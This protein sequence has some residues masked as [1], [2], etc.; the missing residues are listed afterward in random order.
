MRYRLAVARIGLLAFAVHVAAAQGSPLTQPLQFA[1]REPVF[2]SVASGGE[3]VDA[4]RA[5]VLQRRIALEL[6]DASLGDALQTVSR[7][8]GLLINYSSDEL[9]PIGR[10]SVGAHNLTVE[11]AL[12][13]VLL[14][15][16][17]DVEIAGNQ[18][19]LVRRSRVVVPRVVSRRRQ[20][21]GRIEGRVT[22]VRSA[23]P[24]AN[25]TVV[26][27]ATSYHA[28]TKND[29]QY[30]IA[31]IPTGAYTV[32]ARL[33]GHAPLSKRVQIYADSV[34]RI[35]FKLAEAVAALEQV[36]TTAVGDQRRV[37]LGNAI[38]TINADSV[39]RDAP[40]TQVTDVLSGRAP[41]VEVL[42][43]E[44][45]VGV[46]P[47]I[48]IRGLSSFTLSNDPII[49]VD[50]VRVDGT[51]GAVNAT[52]PS[53]THF[54]TPSRLN[55]IDP[56]NIAS[57]DVLKGPSAAT[58]YGTDA[59]NGVIVI[60]TKRGR[61]GVP[62]WDL[63]AEQGMS[64][65]PA[66]YALAWYAWGHTTDSTHAAV[67]CPRTFG[68]GG[69]TIGNG[70]CVIDSVTTYQPLDHRATSLFGTGY[71]SRVGA[72]LSG[73]A[74]Q[75]QYFLSGGYNN[76]TG[77][78]ELP[79]FFQE[80]ERVASG[81]KPIPSYV[82]RPNVMSQATVRG[83]VTAT[84]GP[85][86]DFGFSSGYMSTN[87]RAGDD[88]LALSGATI[89]TGNRNDGFGG[90]GIFGGFYAPSYS[91]ALTTGQDIRRLLNAAN[92]N[93]RP[94]SWLAARATVGLDLGNRTDNSFQP[95]GPDPQGVTSA[96]GSSGTGYHGIGLVSTKLFTTD[97]GVTATVRP[98]I[99]LTSKTS[100]GLQ[101]NTH[102]QTGTLSQAYGLTGAG[103]LNGASVYL[104]SQIDSEARTFGSYVE[105]S[106][107]WR[108]RLFLSGAVRV[109]AGS[110]FGSQVNA[111][112]YPKASLSWMVAQDRSHRLRLRAAYGESGVQPPNG[113]TLSLYTP[114]TVV[115]AGQTTGGD[116]A[117]VAGNRSLQPER[118][119]EL[120]AGLD[121]GVLNDR[122]TLELTYYRKQTHNT[123][124][125]NILP[126][127]DGGRIE[128]ENL[129]SV[130]NYGVEGTLTAHVVDTRPVG[131]S[132]TV[133]GALNANRLA[134]LAPGVP[135]VNA[136]FFP[137]GIQYRQVVGYPLFGYW[138]PQLQY[139]DANHDGIIE[140]SEVSQT[141]TL[142]YVG[143]STPTREFT[144]NTGLSLFA[145]AVRLSAQVDY[146]GGNKIEN[147]LRANAEEVPSA[148]AFNDPHASLAAQA[149]ADESSLSFAPISGAY[150][151]DGSFV[152]WRELSV[153][154]VLP[155]HVVHLV[156][157]QSAS[158]TLLGRNLA[159]WT[160]YS[161]PDPEV[162]TRSTTGSPDAAVDYGTTP[163]VRSWAF[164]VDVGL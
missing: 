121:A 39:V 164:R 18:A 123:I 107:G 37:E 157:A 40:V 54:P 42:E 136:P 143:S 160:R 124:V 75:L 8:S 2:F 96:P 111:A 50:G 86:A 68:G 127:S 118:S 146:R 16:G 57:I 6:N 105:E 34:V 93:W 132:V 83:R 94:L 36:V 58:E 3:R 28:V 67:Q 148:V 38:V 5:A 73:G 48:R 137:F 63:H 138:A 20:A 74:Q 52:S 90:Y 30:A 27:D 1:S 154:Y 12:T 46:G 131:W 47:R 134:S 139:A 153:T 81:G 142:Y 106:I 9:P 88:G 144:L 129:G 149:R 35:D 126:G 99:E 15:T 101:Y 122:L 117:T 44:G 150:F 31:G 70:G 92:G 161:G 43:Q 113:A 7:A 49:Y 108:D 102:A 87:Q 80:Q 135:P 141:S 24:V 91:F 14:G 112:V 158:V 22:D 128:Y 84:L 104:V 95:A 159:L 76:T 151:E 130:R 64:T 23:Q 152:R 85:T 61:A 65:M 66:H 32:T 10:V 97:F 145:D 120:E 79:P 100:V 78:L 51:G 89:G 29:G 21:A 33:L 71:D 162:T 156:R 82:L 62:R 45:Q 13:V 140:A 53:F 116:T 98:A 114:A 77:V 69:P 11:A 155:S 4:R 60:K 125:A 133:G 19:T 55:D 41:G 119:A 147:N 56:A 26:V 103:S 72:Q 115:V 25:A 59:A 163:L 17:L 109:D 110:G